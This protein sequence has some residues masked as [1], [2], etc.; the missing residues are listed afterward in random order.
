MPKST[1]ITIWQWRSSNSYITYSCRTI[2]DI[3]LQTFYPFIT[4]RTPLLTFRTPPSPVYLY[5]FESI[6]LNKIR[7]LFRSGTCLT[8]P[9]VLTTPSNILILIILIPTI[10]QNALLP[11]NITHL[12]LFI[13]WKPVPTMTHIKHATWIKNSI[14][15]R[16]EVVIRNN[17]E[18]S[19]TVLIFYNTGFIGFFW[20]FILLICNNFLIFIL[21]LITFKFDVPF[22]LIA[23]TGFVFIT[24][25]RS[26][27]RITIRI[28]LLCPSSNNK[29]LCPSLRSDHKLLHIFLRK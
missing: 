24:K 11:I 18:F 17:Y 16:F 26:A 4:T 9:S 1:N 19:I 6:V 10:L 13:C 20:L 28:P 27:P 3:I 14:L 25:F 15:A 23:P 5:P 29:A 7:F 22:F 8:S 21:Q 12:T 2:Q